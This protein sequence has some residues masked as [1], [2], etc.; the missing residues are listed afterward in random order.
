MS[1]FFSSQRSYD[2]RAE[3]AAEDR[4]SEAMLLRPFVE[5]VEALRRDLATAADGLQWRDAQDGLSD[6]D[7]VLDEAAGALRA[8]MKELNDPQADALINALA[9]EDEI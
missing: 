5:R 8:A 9:P 2:A 7:A 3:D 6:V 1:S 4:A